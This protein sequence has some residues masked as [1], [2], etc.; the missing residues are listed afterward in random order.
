MS[1]ALHPRRVNLFFLHGAKLP[2]PDGLLEGDG[3]R[4]RRAASKSKT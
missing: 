1:I 4:V 3:A 2:D